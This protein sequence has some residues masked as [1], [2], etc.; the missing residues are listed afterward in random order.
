MLTSESNFRGESMR[1][2]F[3]A[4]LFASG[5]ADDRT[6]PIAAA[7][8][9]D[10]AAGACPES[11]A[12]GDS[13]PVEE[14]SGKEI[15]AEACVACPQSALADHPTIS[16]LAD[17]AL[18]LAGE[19]MGNCQFL[20][21][22]W[23][24]RD[25]ADL[26]GVWARVASHEGT[27]TPRGFTWE[28]DRCPCAG[29]SW[30]GPCS[31]STD[32]YV[33]GCF[34]SEYGGSGGGGATYTTWGL[35]YSGPD[36]ALT[37]LADGFAGHGGGA[38]SFSEFREQFVSFGELALSYDGIRVRDGN[39]DLDGAW[40]DSTGIYL[41]IVEDHELPS[42]DLCLTSDLYDV[43][44]CAIEPH[45]SFRVQG[46]EDVVVTFEGD[47]SCDGCGAV[48]IDGVTSGEFCGALPSDWI[49]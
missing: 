46:Q 35:A 38:S 48:T 19:P 45:G 40:P 9:V 16:T 11:V 6:G 27:G 3:L 4:G 14:D 42:G 12:D 41:R 44:G 39:L 23:E 43:E 21:D 7:V 13:G 33:V 37:Y 24:L 34:D 17:M 5:C 20:I 32:W 25:V 30:G 2:L 18:E 26:T 1:A 15:A 36:A 22:P 47:V 49:E 31:T 29:A 28:E 8:A 10:T